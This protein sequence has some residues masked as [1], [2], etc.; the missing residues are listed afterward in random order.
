M[1]NHSDAVNTLSS[2][3]G[4]LGNRLFLGNLEFTEMKAV[5]SAQQ[6]LIAAIRFVQAEENLLTAAGRKQVAD[7]EHFVPDF[8]D[9]SDSNWYPACGG[10]EEPF[11]ARS[12]ARL[13]YCYQPSTGNHAY[14]NLDTDM[15]LTQEESEG[16]MYLY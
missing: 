4:Y 7:Y 3:S 12:G 14:L 1:S 11:H 10:T 9:R 16:H 5:N 8:S 15:I 13:L 6:I 2:A